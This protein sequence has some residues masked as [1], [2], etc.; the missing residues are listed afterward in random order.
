LTPKNQQAN[1]GQLSPEESGLNNLVCTFSYNR[2]VSLSLTLACSGVETKGLHVLVSHCL[3]PHPRVVWK[4]REMW[5]K[6]PCPA[7]RVTRFSP[8]HR[9]S[10]S[11]SACLIALNKHLW[12]TRNS[13]SL[14]YTIIVMMKGKYMLT[15]NIVERPI[16][17]ITLGRL[18]KQPS[19]NIPFT[20]G[21]H[22][23][24]L[25]THTAL[26]QSGLHAMSF[27]STFCK[28]K[29]FPVCLVET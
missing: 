29:L 6:T 4:F 12:I 14:L 10:V 23:A 16:I 28:S 8:V 20:H 1:P 13:I 15:T 3:V 25:S 5:V 22:F 19:Y 17:R 18:S 27:S 11:G 21:V 2:Y 7:P 26:P 24:R 9:R